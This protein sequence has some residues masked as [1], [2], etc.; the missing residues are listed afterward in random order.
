MIMERGEKQSDPFDNETTAAPHGGPLILAHYMPWYDGPSVK[1]QETNRSVYGGHWTRWGYVNCT[2]A[3]AVEG[4]KG[5]KALIHAKQYP[6][7]G[8][9]H[10]GNTALL[11]YQ[12]SLMKIA[13]LDGVVFDWYGSVPRNDFGKIHE[14]TKAM[15]AVLR[16]AGLKFTACY[17]DNTL[18]MIFTARGFTTPVTEDTIKLGKT[19]FDWMQDNW[20]PDVSYVR[21]GGRPVV[22][23]FGPQHFTTLAQWDEVFAN[24][25]HRPLFVVFE[26][27]AP[28]WGDAAF[29]WPPVSTGSVT[30]RNRVENALNIFFTKRW[31]TPFKI[32]SV[33]SAFDDD[34]LNRSYGYMPYKTDASGSGTDFFDLTWNKVINEYNPNMIQI[35][36]WNDYGAGTIIG[37]TIGRGYNEL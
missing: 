8:P 24:L 3:T 27:Q 16:Q 7:T 13:G 25:K 26:G 15:V 5:K 1:S 33:Y 21:Y 28:A 18:N 36:S 14:H 10:S 2:Y 37:P 12:A 29:N 4:Y 23:N 6:L 19:S 31:Q 22:F 32:A 34:Y 35:V 11:E 20:F 17:E 30:D 9:Y